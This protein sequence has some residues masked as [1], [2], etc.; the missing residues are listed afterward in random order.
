MAKREDV[1]V[2]G[3]RDDPG[4][5]KSLNIHCSITKQT[6]ISI[7]ISLQFLSRASPLGQHR[8]IYNPRAGPNIHFT[9]RK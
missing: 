9:L 4:S 7:G 5:S 2:L 6:W 1:D 8:R 3:E